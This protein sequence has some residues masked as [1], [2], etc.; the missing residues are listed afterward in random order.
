MKAIITI[1][2]LAA[3]CAM[4]SNGFLFGHKFKNGCDPNP[5]KHKGECKLDAKNPNISTCICTG[6]YTGKHCEG[7]FG[8]LSKP[9]KKGNCTNDPTDLTKFICKCEK[10]MVGEKCDTTDPCLKNPCKVGRCTADHKGKAHCSCPLGYGS[11]KCDKKNCTVVQFKG[12]NV[13]KHSPKLFVDKE[14]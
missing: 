3:F 9:C 8:C 13:E 6:D 1:V 10:G 11:D 14:F 2:V 12:K 7:K 4:I 5:C